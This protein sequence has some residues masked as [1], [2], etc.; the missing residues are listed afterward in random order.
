MHSENG[1]HFYRKPHLEGIFQSKCRLAIQ[2]KGPAP[3]STESC[4][5]FVYVRC[6]CLDMCVVGT[7]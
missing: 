2:H 6:V 1:D 3:E 5:G 7:Q 4:T